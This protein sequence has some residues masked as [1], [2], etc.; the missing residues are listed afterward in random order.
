MCSTINQAVAVEVTARNGAWCVML[1]SWSI[2]TSLR[3]AHL[4]SSPR[5]ETS[6][7]LEQP[8]PGGSRQVV[9]AGRRSGNRDTPST[10]RMGGVTDFLLGG[11]LVPSVSPFR[12]SQQ[13]PRKTQSASQSA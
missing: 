4:D 5:T 1:T 8:Q 13:P 2:R 6:A 7:A 3:T 12:S 11:S 9:A 10:E